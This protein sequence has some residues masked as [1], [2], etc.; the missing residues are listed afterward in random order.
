MIER[1]VENQAVIAVV[2]SIIFCSMMIYKQVA[3][4]YDFLF[5]N[6]LRTLILAVGFAV[7]DRRNGLT[8]SLV[9]SNMFDHGNLHYLGL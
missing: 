7:V 3:I 9:G 1:L 6:G 4:K 8:S 2:S 5:G